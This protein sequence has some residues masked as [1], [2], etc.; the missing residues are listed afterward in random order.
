MKKSLHV[1]FLLFSTLNILQAQTCDCSDC[2]I[3]LPDNTMDIRTIFVEQRDSNMHQA[4]APLVCG[5]YINFD[6]QYVG[7]LSMK[8]VSP[9]GESVELIGQ[10]GLYGET[11][12]TSW[13][14]EFT[15][16]DS[17]VAPDD[18]FSDQWQNNQ[19]WGKGNYYT[20]TYYPYGVC[21]QVFDTST[22]EGVWKLEIIDGQPSDLGNFIDFELIFCDSFIEYCSSVANGFELSKSTLCET[23]SVQ[24]TCLL[25]TTIFTQFLWTFPG[26]TPTI[27]TAANPTIQYNTNGVY[28]VFLTVYSDTD[29]INYQ[30]LDK[31]L[32]YKQPDASFSVGIIDTFVYLQGASSTK[33]FWNGLPFSPPYFADT[34][35]IVSIMAI[36]NTL[37][38]ADTV[39]QSINFEL[40]P[41]ADFTY[42]SAAT[43]L[44]EF[45]NTSIQGDTFEWDFGNNE[46]S[47]DPNP[48]YLYPGPG[49]YTVKLKATNTL[50]S[51]LTTK[52]IEVKDVSD[53]ENLSF[54]APDYISVSPNPTKGEFIVY[55]TKFAINESVRWSAHDETGR[56]LKSGKGS[57]PLAKFDFSGYKHGVYLLKVQ[58]D[59]AVWTMKIVVY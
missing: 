22:I 42:S 6:H 48:S 11:D 39:V 38:G 3:L 46:F 18:G 31:V 56:F 28:D 50:G 43:G 24:F 15:R 10:I 53:T 45:Q 27:S 14:V 49:L 17:V 33:Y 52:V 1:L 5:V 35:G 29:I 32:V 51:D 19:N 54:Y 25:D 47:T 12:G 9:S 4:N 8:L 58:G 57:W 40:M 36:S 26:G 44:V 55:G 21:L 7:D 41:A 2:P 20:G 37:C 13:G 59:N 23:D 30:Q 34:L 16:C